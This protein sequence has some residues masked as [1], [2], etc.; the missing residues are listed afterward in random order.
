MDCTRITAQENNHQ[1]GRNPNRIDHPAA[2][3]KILPTKETKR[4]GDRDTQCSGLCGN[5]AEMKRS[6]F[7]SIAAPIPMRALNR[8]ISLIMKWRKR[9]P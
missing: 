7:Q 3:R 6:V 2:I 1:T 9:S 8:T 4:I 5:R